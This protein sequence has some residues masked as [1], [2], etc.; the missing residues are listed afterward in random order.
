M[1]IKELSQKANL[2]NNNNFIPCICVIFQK[3]N[4]LYNVMQRLEITKVISHL[5]G[6]DYYVV[7]N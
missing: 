6:L 5:S 1:S 4:F 7:K 3:T 2:K